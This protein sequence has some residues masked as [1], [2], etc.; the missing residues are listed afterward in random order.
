MGVDTG[1]EGRRGDAEVLKKDI[2]RGVEER[3]TNKE[4]K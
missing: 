1:N 4:E 2:G 3:G